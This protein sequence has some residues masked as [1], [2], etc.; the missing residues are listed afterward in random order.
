MTM[1]AFPSATR[2]AAF[3]AGLFALISINVFDMQAR[4]DEDIR[5]V[6]KK[7]SIINEDLQRI[8]DVL[9]R[10]RIDKGGTVSGSIYFD[11]PKKEG[12]PAQR[13]G[14]PGIGLSSQFGHWSRCAGHCYRSV[15]QV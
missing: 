11:V 3:A 15:R 5:D 12:L 7:L 6:I 2:L 10:P 8:A 13:I 1:L 4:A 9:G 14:L